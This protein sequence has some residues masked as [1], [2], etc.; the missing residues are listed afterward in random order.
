[1]RTEGPTRL[2]ASLSEQE[3]LTQELERVRQNLEQLLG[4]WA[5]LNEIAIA[6]AST[7]DEGAVLRQVTASVRHALDA[8][9]AV[10]LL[11]NKDSSDLRPV[12][13]CSAKDTTEQWPLAS[14]FPRTACLALESSSPLLVPDKLD[15]PAHCSVVEQLIDLGPPSILCTP[16]QTKGHTIGVLEL[17][18]RSD[19]SAQRTFSQE[20]L[21]LL[22]TLTPWVSVIAENA[23]L[24][25]SAYQVPAATAIKQIVVA[26]A[27]HINNRLM[28]FSLELDES[29]S[30]KK[31]WREE[32][33]KE[34]LDMAR[35][36][37]WQIS[38]VVKALDVLEEIR[39]V[40]YLGTTDMVDIEQALN[41]QLSK[42]E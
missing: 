37:I 36:H 10:L 16:L 3:R 22:L 32:D 29:E 23:S 11:F 42:S 1:V 5:A 13:T 25:R 17:I 15:E 14:P 18:G 33:V 24:S 26:L 38:A 27:H 35:R 34:L 20:D 7:P 39:A 21:D 6:V 4:N 12:A 30:Q 8:E 19:H 2:P 40:P 31:E 9:L 41:D 28:A